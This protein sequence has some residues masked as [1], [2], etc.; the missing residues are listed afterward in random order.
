MWNKIINAWEAVDVFFIFIIIIGIT[1]FIKLFTVCTVVEAELQ[2]SP[3]EFY[4]CVFKSHPSLLESYQVGVES[5][6]AIIMFWVLMCVLFGFS[7]VYCIAM[8]IIANKK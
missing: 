7:C 2:T 4:V 8:C 1:F 3:V 5:V 6:T